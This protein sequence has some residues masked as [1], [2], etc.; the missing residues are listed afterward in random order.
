MKP[1]VVFFG[2]ALPTEF[3]DSVDDDTTEADL[4]IV[5]GTSLQVYP[6]AG[7]PES[8]PNHIPRI[9]INMEVPHYTPNTFDVILLGES[10]HIA[11]TLASLLHWDLDPSRP[12][13]SLNLILKFTE[14]NISQLISF[15][16][17]RFFLNC[18]FPSNPHLSLS[19]LCL[20]LSSLR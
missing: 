19:L 10:D 18:F 6:V 4:L 3:L 20:P 5:V 17:F 8:V 12:P 13:I 14:P 9:L 15:S 16:P 11:I 1:D 2:E 7:I